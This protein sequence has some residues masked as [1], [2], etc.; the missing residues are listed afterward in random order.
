MTSIVNKC[1]KLSPLWFQQ[2]LELE[3]QVELINLLKS[4]LVFLKNRCTV[5]LSLYSLLLL[6]WFQSSSVLFHVFQHSETGNS[7]HLLKFTKTPFKVLVM[8]KAFKY[9]SKTEAKAQCQLVEEIAEEMK[10]WKK[11]NKSDNPFKTNLERWKEKIMNTPLEMLLSINWL[12]Q[13]NSF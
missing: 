3:T 5:L 7:N 12:K 11:A 10:L 6:F 13:L 1:N 4:I 9:L 8:R 2:Y